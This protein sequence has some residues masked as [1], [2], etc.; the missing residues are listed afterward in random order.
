MRYMLGCKTLSF[1][2]VFLWAESDWFC[3][4]VFCL[5]TCKWCTRGR[6]SHWYLSSL[7]MNIN[8]F[9]VLV[10]SIAL[11][12]HASVFQNTHSHF[13]YTLFV[14][15]NVKLVYFIWNYDFQKQ[16]SW[17]QFYFQ[18]S[19][20]GTDRS[21]LV[22]GLFDYLIIILLLGVFAFCWYKHFVPSAYLK[23]KRD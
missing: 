19:Q 7:N 10:L 6:L 3:V 21:K 18:F 20:Y 15:Y 16:I 13:I 8:H 17:S 23:Q 12:K 9:L 22:I 4:V 11:K 14:T 2:W 5:T 1:C